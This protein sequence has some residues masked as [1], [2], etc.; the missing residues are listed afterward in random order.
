MSMSAYMMPRS[1]VYNFVALR[2]YDYVYDVVGTS[3]SREEWNVKRK[4]SVEVP[5]RNDQ[6][7]WL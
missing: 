7:G 5:Y 6:R 1:C 2:T 4:G 3:G